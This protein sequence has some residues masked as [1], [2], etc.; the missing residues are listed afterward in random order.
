MT[1]AIDTWL[2]NSPKQVLGAMATALRSLLRA[3]D[4]KTRSA[5][6]R[7]E[8][9]L[10]LS[11]AE[12]R[13]WVEREMLS[14]SS[15]R[16]AGTAI[17][18]V[19][20]FIEADGEYVV[21][22]IC[23]W[24][25][26][27]ISSPHTDAA[28][29]VA[30]FLGRSPLVEDAALDPVAS[31]LVPSAID[32][33]RRGINKG[34]DSQLQRE[35]LELLV[36]SDRVVPMPAE[37]VRMAYQVIRSRIADRSADQAQSPVDDGAAAVR[38]MGHLAGTLLSRG[39]TAAECRDLIGDFLLEIRDNNF[40]N[41]IVK[42]LLSMLIGLAHHDPDAVAWMEELFAEEDLAKVVKLAI[43]RAIM[44]IDGDQIGGRAS[45]LK[46]RVD[47]PPEVATYIVTRLRQ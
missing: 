38:D 5:R 34:E 14:R 39:L 23:R 3:E 19:L 10:V 28:Q 18:T 44:Q 47:C 22:S 16:V 17:K 36:R 37:Q 24:L 20:E 11:D 33:M 40:G 4:V 21:A 35:L 29:R 6:A 27:L 32:R 15:P 7:L 31:E 25:T 2:F 12:A 1:S 45:R 9:R 8:G 42:V 13:I 41:R 26:S 46:D 43:A 30:A